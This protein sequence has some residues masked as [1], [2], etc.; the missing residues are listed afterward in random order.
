M[1]EIKYIFWDKLK[2]RMVY[3]YLLDEW[4]LGLSS[5]GSVIGF[6]SKFVDS[7]D[8]EI[9]EYPERFIPLQFTGTLDECGEE[10]YEGDYIRFTDLDSNQ[11]YEGEVAFKGGAFCMLHK[12]EG[13]R[14]ALLWQ[15]C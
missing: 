5:Y 11:G 6:E 4:Q 7:R 12:I 10:I 14:E 15:Q 1:R 2:E 13:A 3:Q 8:C 9:L